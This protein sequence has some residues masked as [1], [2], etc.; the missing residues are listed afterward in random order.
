MREEEQQDY[1]PYDGHPEQQNSRQPNTAAANIVTAQVPPI[2]GNIRKEERMTDDKA[3][4]TR[5]QTAH[6]APQAPARVQPLYC[7]ICPPD[8][9]PNTRR[10]PT[11]IVCGDCYRRYADEA[12]IAL[13]RGGFITLFEWVAAKA[14]TMLPELEEQ[15]G[16]AQ[17]DVR[18]LKANINAEAAARLRQNSGG[19]NIPPEIWRP[20]L[21]ELTQTLWRERGG[22]GKFARMKTLEARIAL[23]QSILAKAAEAPAAPPAGATDPE[24]PAAPPAGATNPETP[25]APVTAVTDPEPPAVPTPKRVRRNTAK[26]TADPA[27]STTK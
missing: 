21:Q 5:S 19:R 8:K 14:A 26:A 10:K 17:A 20:A 16:E 24:P 3:Q 4:L 6:A 27:A 11:D 9:T 22:N 15:S 13:A 1:Q 12:A 18:L 25:A 7:P 2:S 23:M